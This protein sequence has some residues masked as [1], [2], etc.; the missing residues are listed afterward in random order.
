MRSAISLATLA[1]GF[2]ISLQGVEAATAADE[3]TSV[4]FANEQGDQTP[5]TDYSAEGAA[6]A[7]QPVGS[8]KKSANGFFNLSQTYFDN[9]ATGG[10]DALTWEINGSGILLYE[11]PKNIWENKGKAIYGRSE[12]AGLSSRKSADV[13]DLETIYTRK[14]GT[15]V[16]PFASARL[17]TQFDAGYKYDDTS[18]TRV[19]APFD[20]LYLTQTAGVGYTAIKDLN[21]RLGFALKETFSDSRY[22]YADDKETASEIESFLFEPGLSFTTIYKFSPMENIAVSTTLDVFVNFKG[23]E[24]IDGRWENMVTAKVNKYISTNFALD[25]LYDKDLSESRQMKE[26]LSI[27]ISFLSI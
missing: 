3:T 25:L 23:T 4:K 2:T 15:W 10:T 7:A 8:W 11:D 21:V 13:L 9:W 12:I 26:S 22:G 1:L 19:S 5:T 16:N 24:E 6:P 18:S 20:P 27:A 17:Q 14:L